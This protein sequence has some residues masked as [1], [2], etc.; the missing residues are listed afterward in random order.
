MLMEPQRHT[1][2][3]WVFDIGRYVFRIALIVVVA[4]FII[5]FW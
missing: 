5:K 4:H 3:E 2:M 1:L